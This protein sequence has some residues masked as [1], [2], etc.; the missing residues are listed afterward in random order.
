MLNEQLFSE[1]IVER[2]EQTA[3]IGQTVT[4]PCRPHVNKDVDWNF[5]ATK[6]SSP[7]RVYSNGV[8]YDRFSGRFE[9]PKVKSAVGDYDLV[10]SNVSMS[11]A[12]QYVCIEDMGVG[13]QHV[14]ELNVTGKYALLTTRPFGLF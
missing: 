2:R 14:I 12:G 10:I 11:D 8:T 4:L 7:Y 5:R 3:C 9:V 13:D 6:T 1:R